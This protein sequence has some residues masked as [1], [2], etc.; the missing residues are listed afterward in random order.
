MSVGKPLIH[1]G[2]EKN[3]FNDITSLF[4]KEPI[5]DMITNH[6]SKTKKKVLTK[7]QENL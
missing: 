2:A 3:D 7:S 4:P 1:E 6:T 5:L